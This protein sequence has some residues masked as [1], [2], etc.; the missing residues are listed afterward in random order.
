LKNQ[1]FILTRTGTTEQ[2]KKQIAHEPDAKTGTAALPPA[3]ERLDTGY[4]QAPDRY[5]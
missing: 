5:S 2:N 3:S 1:E 4:Q